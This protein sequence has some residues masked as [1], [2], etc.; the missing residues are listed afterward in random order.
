MALAFCIFIEIFFFTMNSVNARTYF[1]KNKEKKSVISYL[2]LHSK[3]FK[4][5]GFWVAMLLN[6]MFI[7]HDSQ[8]SF[9]KKISDM[10]I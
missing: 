4:K 1:L 10:L 2:N 6:I 7:T 8:G 3:R 9:L 5:F